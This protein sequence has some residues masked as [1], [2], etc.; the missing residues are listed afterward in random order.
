MQSGRWA[1]CGAFVIP[2]YK[3]AGYEF[4]IIV[5]D[6]MGWEHVS[7]TV[8][9]LKHNPTRCPTWEEM[10]EIKNMFWFDDQAVVQYHPASKDY[11]NAHPY[12]LHL[13]R[14]V[15]GEF[16]TPNPLLVGPVTGK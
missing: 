15:N 13:W 3:I 1:T 2:H 12:C 4:C 16:P 7:V 8:R 5:T 6:G 9:K 11:V 10:C 14:P